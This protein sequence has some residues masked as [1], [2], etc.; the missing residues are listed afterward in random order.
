MQFL[1][2]SS[3]LAFRPARRLKIA[4]RIVRIVGGI[5]ERVAVVEKTFHEFHR[6]RKTETFAKRDF[7]V[8]HA[9]DFAGEVEQR[10]AAV[11]GIDLRAGLQK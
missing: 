2:F 10:A 9:H 6:D 3:R 11:A 1:F 8:R 7:H 4:E 5:G